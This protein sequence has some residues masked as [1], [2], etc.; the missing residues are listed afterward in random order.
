[1]G[2]AYVHRHTVRFEETNLVG[3][4]YFT[5]YLRW[6]GH[7]REAFLS[8]HAPAVVEE[9][10]TGELALVTVSC[11]VD[12]FAECFAGDVVDIHMRLAAVTG[13]RVEMRFSY[14]RDGVT[15]ATGQQVVACMH[16]G[17][18]GLAAAPVPDALREALRAYQ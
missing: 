18:D 15:V 1:M 4:V 13:N 5:H 6:Q 9:L 7:C 11:A 10:G 3:N 12:F 14:Q 16:R 17:T 8:R 2:S